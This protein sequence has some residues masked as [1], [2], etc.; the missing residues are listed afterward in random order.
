MYNP[1]RNTDFLVFILINDYT[2]NNT[3][4]VPVSFRSVE[5]IF[6]YGS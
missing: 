5:Q 1:S 3:G 4:S 2:L 6:P